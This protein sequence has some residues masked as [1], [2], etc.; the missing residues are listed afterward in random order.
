MPAESPGWRPSLARSIVLRH[1]RVR[2]A[3]LLLMPER[4]VLLNVEA[5]HILRLCDGHRTVA[6]IVAHLA[7]TFPGAP[8]AEDVPEF[9]DRVRGEGWV[10]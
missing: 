6:E 3:D 10:R 8:V 5:G 7:E 2:D 1:D 4:A 9:L